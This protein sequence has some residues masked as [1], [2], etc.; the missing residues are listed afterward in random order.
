MALFGACNPTIASVIYHMVA[1]LMV[2]DNV[3]LGFLVLA[4]IPGL[5]LCPRLFNE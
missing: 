4:V 2:Y 5:A 1:Q 3:N